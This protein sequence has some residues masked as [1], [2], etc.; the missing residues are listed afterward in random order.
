[1]LDFLSMT[2]DNFGPYKGRQVIEYPEK[3]GVVIFWGDN[4]RG[5]TTLLNAFRFALFGTIQRR[6]SAL[7]SLM[8]MENHE[9][10]EEGHY[11]F[12]VVLHMKS[13]KD[14]FLLTREFRPRPGVAVPRHEEDYAKKVF[15][16]KNGSLL[17]PDDTDHELSLLLPE[18]V[19]RFFLFDG[20][21]LQEYE[22]LLI[23]DT[24]TGDRIKSAIERILGVPVLTNG[25]QDIDSIR[26]QL[27][28][29]KAKAVRDDT[30]GRQYANTLDALDS[31]IE[32]HKKRLAE[33]EQELKEQYAE[34][35]K[36]EEQM[37]STEQL[38]EWQ[39]DIDSLRNRREQ[40]QRVLDGQLLEMRAA[41]KDAWRGMLRSRIEE[42]LSD[43]KSRVELLQVKRSQ[44]TIADK[45]LEDIRKAVNDHCCP[46]CEQNVDGQVWDALNRRLRQ[47]IS[48]IGLTPEEE[49]EITQTQEIIR[50]LSSLMRDSARSKVRGIETQITSLRISIDNDSQQIR[51]LQQ[52]ISEF[53]GNSADLD[54]IR[55]LPLRYS[56]VLQKIENLN[57]AK[58]DEKK[59]MQE[60]MDQREKI[61]QSISRLESGSDLR[62]ATIKLD[63]CQDIYALFEEGIGKYR[64]AL[65]EHVE[66]DATEIFVNITGD[67]DYVG[68]Q[69]N[70]NYGLSIVHRTGALVP[71][72][73]SGYEHIVALSLIGALHKNA[74]LRG[75]IIM[76]SPFGRPDKTHK[77]NIAR[78]LPHMAD[79]VI[80]LT[81]NGEIE[82]GVAVDELAENLVREYSLA[83]ITSMHTQIN[84]GV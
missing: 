23:D 10:R 13:G 11:G 59:C 57:E 82:R 17:S 21:L 24:V 4:G 19:S 33:L 25:R 66:H 9:S 1:M 64:D 80:L 18:H 74:P 69:I 16:K 50:K 15:L 45:V 73:S 48:Q 34:Q 54:N 61:M 3:N 67:P 5:K 60:K 27:S 71:G 36:L 8:S 65:R 12:S 77:K 68:L 35:R 44:K 75:P 26:S 39:R 32:E 46:V 52:R 63:L 53:N 31:G 20:E 58:R 22:E 79:Q 83:R 84:Q 55:E 6:N 38:R 47:S 28:K 7:N 51:E 72:R 37:Q 14:D 30:Q 41:M 42:L 81:Y 2:L 43:L 62:E 40:S 29:Q 76:D 78:T 70:R 49:E 56:R